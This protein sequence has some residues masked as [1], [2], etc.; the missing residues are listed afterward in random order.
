[1]KF[2][3][4]QPAMDLLK[5]TVKPEMLDSFVEVILFE[6]RKSADRD[7]HDSFYF[8]YD[9]STFYCKFKN[10]RIEITFNQ[11]DFEVVDELKPCVW[12][13][14]EEFDGNPNEYLL[15]EVIRN[16]ESYRT[17][18]CKDDLDSLCFGATHFMY[19]EKPNA[20]C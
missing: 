8:N 7:G 5:A 16:G 15:V 2:K 1:M 14:R 11:D 13:P 9:V 19:L 17:S 20:T 4:K 10:Q 3:L 6:A 18:F 12:Y